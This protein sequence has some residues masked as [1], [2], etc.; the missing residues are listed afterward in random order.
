MW[1]PKPGWPL[2]PLSACSATST[3]ERLFR[4]NPVRLHL[5]TVIKR[6][7]VGPV[8]VKADVSSDGSLRVNQLAFVG[9]H[10]ILIVTDSHPRS[11]V[12]GVVE[13][14]PEVGEESCTGC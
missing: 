1:R 6:S 12:L 9:L 14:R 2:P 8:A 3:N 10:V 5:D 13:D 4:R 11:V 7:G